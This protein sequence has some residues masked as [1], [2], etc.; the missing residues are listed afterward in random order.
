MNA[1]SIQKHHNETYRLVYPYKLTKRRERNRLGWI[2][3]KLL[4]K[5]L[6]RQNNERGRRERKNEPA[7]D[8]EQL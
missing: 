1:L 3:A 8:E 4:R 7:E 5:P 6:E 2:T